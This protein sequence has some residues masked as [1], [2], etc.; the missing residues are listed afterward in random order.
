MN[1]RHLMIGILMLVMVMVMQSVSPLSNTVLAQPSQ[2]P[3]FKSVENGEYGSAFLSNSTLFAH[4]RVARGGTLQNPETYLNFTIEGYN[5]CCSFEYGQGKIPNGDLTGNAVNY[6]HLK[7]DLNTNPQ[8]EVSSP[9][10]RSV[11]DVE[12]VAPPK[13]SVT[14]ST[15]TTRSAFGNVIDFYQGTS[16]DRFA[17]LQ[18][19]TLFGQSFDDAYANIGTN[20]NVSHTIQVGPPN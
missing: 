1:R 11:I 17:I 7:T 10:L 4:V 16:E 3:Q 14:T 12:W 20:H 15:G 9:A 19:K 18:S 6:L 5:P 8:F 13:G 2:G